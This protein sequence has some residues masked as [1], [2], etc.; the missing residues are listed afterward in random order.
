MSLEMLHAHHGRPWTS[1]EIQDAIRLHKSGMT[2]AQVADELCRT[3]NAVLAALRKSVHRRPWTAEE[4]RQC[5]EWHKDG[6]PVHE[7]ATRLGRTKTSTGIRVSLL[8]YGRTNQRQ[9][10]SL[11][12]SGVPGWGPFLIWRKTDEHPGRT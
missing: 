9:P 3:E 6:I 11:Q 1:D 5:L 2:W 4:D 10:H 8:L 7:I 12:T